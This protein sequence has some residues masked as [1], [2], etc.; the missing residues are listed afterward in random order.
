MAK[1]QCSAHVTIRA[2]GKQVVRTVII[3]RGLGQ[4]QSEDELRAWAKLKNVVVYFQRKAW[5]D[6]DFFHWYLLNVFNKDVRESGDHADQLLML[7]NLGAH[8]T[9]RNR[10]LM[11]SL[12]IVPHFLALNCTD[13]AAPIDHHVGNL[14]KRLMKG[15]Y[16]ED[17]EK[18]FHL[19]RGDGDDDRPSEFL[20]RIIRRKKMAGWLDLAWSELREKNVFFLKAFVSTGCLIG[21]NGENGIKMRGLDE[22][23]RASDD[24]KALNLM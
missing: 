14:L 11:K 3:F 23:L 17:L 24:F 15:F 6:S 21:L 13:V 9:K 19:W 8:K 4:T 5:C 2:D 1:R 20:N 16:E 10:Q 12:G 18:F 22:L 7:D